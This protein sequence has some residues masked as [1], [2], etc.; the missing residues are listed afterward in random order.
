MQRNT[1]TTA[2][3]LKVGDR[4]YKLSD[5]KK[6]PFEIV[7]GDTKVTH[8][9]TYKLFCCACDI[10]DNKYMSEALK[11]RQYSALVKDTQVVYLR[12]TNDEPVPA[13]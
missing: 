3:A 7:Q 12:S 10:L 9:R 11:R 2:G 13:F 1:I 5:K 6:K 8:F 4:F